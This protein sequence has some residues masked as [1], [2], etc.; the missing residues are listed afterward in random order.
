M[1]AK[2]IAPGGRMKSRHIEALF[3]DCE[4]RWREYR[5]WWMSSFRN[6]NGLAQDRW[7]KRKDSVTEEIVRLASEVLQETKE[8]TDET[9]TA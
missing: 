4:Q 9:D 1:Q 6:N 3:W 8:V 5:E 2:G 7:S